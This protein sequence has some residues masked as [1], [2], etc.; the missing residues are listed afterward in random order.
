MGAGGRA[1]REG[2]GSKE[3]T[4]TQSLGQGLCWASLPP[5]VLEQ[6]QGSER[7]ASFRPPWGSSTRPLRLP[8]SLS[9]D[10]CGLSQPL[11]EASLHLFPP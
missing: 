6:I 5:A 1:E 3:T 10:L 7:Q 11:P 2:G 4:D 8:L 9:R